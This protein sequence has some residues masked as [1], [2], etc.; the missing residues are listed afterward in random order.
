M[1]EIK[2]ATRIESAPNITP[3]VDIVFLLLIFFLLTAFFIQPEGLGIKLPSADAP[4]MQAG[5]EIEIVIEPSGRVLMG[6]EP[7]EI[8]EIE[9]RVSLALSAGPERAVVRKSDREIALQR[10]VE[11]MDKCRKA[12]A[13]RLVIATQ[14]PG[15]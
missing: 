10:V 2:P 11:V 14:S 12:G 4:A 9:G 8:S 1:I 5:E 6:G 3:L 13:E 15:P 7:V